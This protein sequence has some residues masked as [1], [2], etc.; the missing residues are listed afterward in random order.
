M[1]DEATR[2]ATIETTYEDPETAARV[3]AA[4]RP[5]DTDEMATAVSGST[6]ETTIA[7]DTTGGLR[8]TVDDYVVNLAVAAQLADRDGE[9]S[10]DNTDT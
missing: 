9:P 10:T 8:A 4:V 2:R 3:A 1:S 6:V 5:D 7:R